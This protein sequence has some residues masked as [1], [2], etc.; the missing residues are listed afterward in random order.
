M[1]KLLYVAIVLFAISKL[2]HCSDASHSIGET[3]I[4]GFCFGPTFELERREI[5]N[6]DNIFTV[7]G[8]AGDEFTESQFFM[9]KHGV[10]EG[11]SFGLEES[12]LHG[13]L[14]AKK[15]MH[16]LNDRAYKTYVEKYLRVKK[17]CPVSF[18]HQNLETVLLIPASE[19][20]AQDFENYELPFSAEGTPFKFEGYFMSAKESYAI[21]DGNRLNITLASHEAAMSNKG[22]AQHLIR[23]FLVTRIY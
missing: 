5:S 12:H 19:L 20:I 9:E 8:Y 16:I 22:S 21:R 2:F 15:R 6:T 7:T 17:Q 14:T 13:S 23:Y 4:F 3:C 1:K 18:I 11:L 10:Y